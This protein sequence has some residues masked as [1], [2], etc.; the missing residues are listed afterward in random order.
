M[1]ATAILYFRNREIL[2][3]NGAWWARRITA[4]NLVKIGQSVAEI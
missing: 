3:V 4:S 1:V 2:L